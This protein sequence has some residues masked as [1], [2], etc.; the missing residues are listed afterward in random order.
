M[1]IS[2]RHLAA[3]AVFALGAASFAGCAAQQDP[4]DSTDENVGEADEALA[5]CCSE[6]SYRCASN[7]YTVDY[8]QP[9]CGL[10]TKITAASNCKSHCGNV[11]CIDS[12]WINYCL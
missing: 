6:G 7:S 9:G 5:N 10:P 2:L 11:S 8:G 1:N 12:G 3:L 4:A